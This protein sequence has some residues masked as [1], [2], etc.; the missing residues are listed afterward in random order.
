MVSALG[1]HLSPVLFLFA[2]GILSSSRKGAAFRAVEQH[3]FANR[4]I[5][6]YLPPYATEIDGSAPLTEKT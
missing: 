1:T 4:R 3:F 2:V 6:G 5:D